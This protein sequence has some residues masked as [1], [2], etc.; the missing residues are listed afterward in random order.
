MVAGPGVN[1]CSND[2]DCVPPP[3]PSPSPSPMPL[4]L[5]SEFL[6]WPKQ[7]FSSNETAGA[8]VRVTNVGGTKSAATTVGL[9]PTG[10]PLPVCPGS[11]QTPPAGQSYVVSELAPG[12]STDISIS[13]NVGL[14]PGTFTAYAYVIP[15]CNQP[16]ASW[17]NNQS[18]GVTYTV[19]ARAWFETIAGDVGAKSRVQVSQTPP[20]G[21]YQTSYLMAANPIDTSVAVDPG[22]WWTNSYTPLLI[23]A[24]GAYQYLAD[25][26][27]A[28]AKKN[29]QPEV[30]GHCTIPA[31]VSTGLKYCAV[32]GRFQDGT[33]PKGSSVWFI[34]GNLL[35]EKNLQL[36][37]ED[38]IVFVVKGD[39]TLKTEVTRADGIY[40]TNG[41]FRDTTDDATILG[42]QLIMRGGVV[43]RTTTLNRK[44]GGACGAICNNVTDPAEQITFEPKYLVQLAPLLGSPS[45]SWKEVAP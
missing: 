24:G 4:D 20:A 31:G 43:A 22:G 33:A 45:I 40:I 14:T 34:D 16:D 12:A 26:F 6:P 15:A 42:A 19:S 5:K 28:A 13:F 18:G 17:P 8:T 44:L 38:T 25:R 32:N 23:P 30:G 36:A 10:A 3:P 37:P 29:P 9:W 11:P 21:R 2:A 39:I 41:N 35:I 1:E 7:F 27:L